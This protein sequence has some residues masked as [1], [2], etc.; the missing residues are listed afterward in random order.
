MSKHVD[1]TQQEPGL[2]DPQVINPGPA[3]P[4]GGSPG[5]PQPPPQPPDDIP[6]PHTQP[7]VPG[8]PRLAIRRGN[9]PFR[10]RSPLRHLLRNRPSHRRR[11]QPL[12]ASSQ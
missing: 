1:V 3:P 12:V 5:Q 2:L 7:P 6:G 9:R 10:H 4:V 8:T 11:G